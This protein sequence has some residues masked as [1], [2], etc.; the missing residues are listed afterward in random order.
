MGTEY[1]LVLYTQDGLR[2]AV[3]DQAVDFEY[4]R[5]LNGL[6]RFH[7][8]LPVG[9]DKALIAKNRRIGFWRKPAGGARSQDF[10]G[11]VT[12]PVRRQSTG[13]VVARAIAGYSS[14]LLLR[15]KFVNYSAGSSQAEQSGPADNVMK[16]IVRENLGSSASGARQL[17]STIFS[18]AS[19]A[20]RG[21]TIS[22]AFAWK[23]VLEILQELSNDAR[24]KGTEVYF[25]VVPVSENQVEFR[26]YIGQPGA[27]RTA[28]GPIPLI[29]GVDYD[30]LKD[31]EYDENFDDE[32]N[33]VSA[34]GQGEGAARVRATAVTPEA[35]NNPFA[36]AELFLDARHEANGNA[37]LDIAEAELIAQ[38]G[39]RRFSTQIQEAPGTI[40]GVDW[41]FGDRVTAT[42]DGEQFDCLIRAVEVKVDGNGKEQ[43]TATL[44]AFV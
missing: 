33:A 2:L 30:N 37:L 29:V 14:N 15:R 20:G 22:R 36:R 5:V 11:I 24:Q 44:E 12:R 21:P 9:F 41:S 3:I 38:R 18:V 6:G 25:D 26:T 32:V 13:T 16:A 1:E 43:I 17:P 35:S 42:F 40:Y 34:G 28:G 10:H 27:D 7:V 19:D 4:L 31:A 39:T 23:N 8:N